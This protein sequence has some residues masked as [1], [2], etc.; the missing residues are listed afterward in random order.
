M[1]GSPAG[2]APRTSPWRL[3]LRSL[4]T[5]TGSLLL[6]VAVV[7]AGFAWL[8]GTTAGMNSMIGLVNRFVPGIQIDT[9]GAFGELA[10][11]FGFAEVRVKVD[12][13]SVHLSGLRARP[14]STD[15]MA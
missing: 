3:L 10:G 7:A 13:A 12:R 5:G 1:F 14:V 9:Q 11:E 15:A 6:S 2:P 8:L 4:A